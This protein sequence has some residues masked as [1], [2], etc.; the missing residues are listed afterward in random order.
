[1]FRS[2]MCCIACS[3]KRKEHHDTENGDGATWK[4][5][6]EHCA[7]C[8]NLKRHHSNGEMGPACVNQ[9][10][11]R[12]LLETEWCQTKQNHHDVNLNRHAFQLK[13]VTV[14]LDASAGETLSANVAEIGASVLVHFKMEVNPKLNCRRP[15]VHWSEHSP[16][17][18]LNTDKNYL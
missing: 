9:R 2:R 8:G 13:S 1:M 11:L 4:C 15:C 5:L 7:K 6:C 16:C 18:A 12:C 14:D 10:G 17:H 3:H